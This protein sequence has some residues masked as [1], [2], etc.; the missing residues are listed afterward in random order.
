MNCAIEGN[1]ATIRLFTFQI[2][3]PLNALEVSF[4]ANNF[5]FRGG[6][7][8]VD[9]KLLANCVFDIVIG[10]QC[11]EHRAN[12]RNETQKLKNKLFNELLTKTMKIPPCLESVSGS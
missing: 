4:Q 3:L 5:L 7:S 1:D 6:I 10:P 11:G 9:N 2:L 8:P 12:E